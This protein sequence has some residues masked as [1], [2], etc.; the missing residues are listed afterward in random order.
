MSGKLGRRAVVIG[1]GIG[2]LAA[3]GAL[4]PY[5][6]QV[7]IVERDVLAGSAASR[8]GTPQDRH[9]HGLLA[10][11]LKALDEIYPGFSQ[12]LTKAGAV[13]VGIAQDVRYERGDVGA[14]PMRDLGIS[15][16]GATRPL[17]EAVLRNCATAVSNIAVHSGCRV[18]AIVPS[19]RGADVHGVHIELRS[20]S[21][22]TLE[23]DLVIDASGRGAPTLMLFDALS[24]ARPK[25]SEVGVD[26]SYAT[27]VLDIPDEAPTWKLA[28][29][30]P[31]PP[32]QP[33]NALLLPVEG[34]RWM[35]TIIDYGAPGQLKTWE[36][37]LAA[38]RR[39]PTPSIYQAIRHATPPESLSHYGF[40][41]S[42]WRHFEQLPRLPR[43]VLPLGDS[44]CRFN[45]IY[46]Q[47][48]SSAARQARL[49]REML[50]RVAAEPD[51]IAAVQ[52]GFMAEIPGVVE[53]PWSMSTRTDLAF[54]TT[55]GERP[56][57]FEQSRQFDIAL[58]RAVIAD[59]VVHRAM[60]EVAQ[61]LAPRSL[62][63]EPHIKA[64]IE[65]VAAKA[66]A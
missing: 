38:A 46:G 45:P 18:S 7:D 36:D 50:E 58:F 22:K 56:E 4:A 42:M 9:S 61:L 33:L 65:A 2:G 57:N 1:A 15:I 23:A 63:Q 12:Q 49:L 66:M 30:L 55:R 43:G 54:P 52:A 8:T 13:A 47:G 6:E 62:L 41:A 5:F 44:I 48:M 34:D 19:P 53:A 51:P 59:P 39:L 24:W 17:I 32:T 20:G 37:L 10:G 60:V 27:A 21:S 64:R 3:A 29:T 14:L 35:V 28:I 26:I 11:G 25:L 31:S 16:R 40:A